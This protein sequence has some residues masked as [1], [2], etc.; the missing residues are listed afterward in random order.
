MPF[1]IVPGSKELPTI[2]PSSLPSM[3]S[4]TGA[5][6]FHSPAPFRLKAEQGTATLCARPG[7]VLNKTTLATIRLRRNALIVSVQ[8]I[9]RRMPHAGSRAVVAIFVV[10]PLMILADFLLYLLAWIDLWT[11]EAR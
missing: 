9:M 11:A 3:W 4:M 2:G 7:P 5:S 1:V 6:T 10:D 8:Y